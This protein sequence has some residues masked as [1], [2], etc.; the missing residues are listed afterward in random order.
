MSADASGGFGRPAGLFDLGGDSVAAVDERLAPEVVDPGIGIGAAVSRQL[1]GTTDAVEVAAEQ[2]LKA[3]EHRAQ[4]AP[5]SGVL[6]L[7]RGGSRRYR[8]EFPAARRR[9]RARLG[10]EARQQA[11]IDRAVDGQSRSLPE[12]AYR[13]FRPAAEPSVRRSR[14]VPQ[15][16]ELALSVGDLPNGGAVAP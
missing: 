9:A 8:C 6:R 5:L 10:V 4:Y 14:I 11:I 7:G 2:P 13:R 3:A 15:G 16:G 1:G 12:L